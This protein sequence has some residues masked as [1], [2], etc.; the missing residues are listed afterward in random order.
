VLRV[1]LNFVLL[2]REYFYRR[3]SHWYACGILG[4]YAAKMSS[5]RRRTV[6]L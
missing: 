1:F 6:R 2:R 5:A 4:C 3:T